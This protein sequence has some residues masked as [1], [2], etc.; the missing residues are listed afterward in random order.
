MVT[1]QKLG[2]GVRGIVVGRVVAKTLA[3]EKG[4]HVEGNV[5]FPVRIDDSMQM[6]VHRSCGAGF[7]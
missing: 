4:H 6:R 7:D 3:K 1:F 2:G 5:S